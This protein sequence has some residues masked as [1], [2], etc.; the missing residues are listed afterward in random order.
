MP[1]RPIRARLEQPDESE[2]ALG[3]L[4]DSVP[5]FV[6]RASRVL[7]QRFG[8]DGARR[9]NRPVFYHAFAL[10]AAN[11]GI[12]LGE[13]A[14]CM[15]LDQSRASELVEVLER[16]AFVTRRRDFNDQRRRGIYL[17]PAGTE[18]LAQLH[19]EVKSLEANAEPA[20]SADDTQHLID[21]LRR[22]TRS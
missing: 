1:V 4:E 15:A 3:L 10:V 17:T 9:D 22:L 6:L 7:L 13:L 12:S 21:L 16:R 2:V 14:T 19:T 5:F 20:L 18:R 11:P 8:R